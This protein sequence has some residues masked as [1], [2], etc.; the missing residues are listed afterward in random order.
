MESVTIFYS[1]YSSKKI[2]D[3]PVEEALMSIKKPSWRHKKRVLDIREMVK[4]GKDYEKKKAFLPVIMWTGTFFNSKVAGL[5]KPNNF[6]YVDIDN[7]PSIDL[8]TIPFV[9]AYWRSVSG[10]G[11]G[12]LV[13]SKNICHANYSATYR[14]VADMFHKYG[15]IVDKQTCNI[16][17]GNA[18]SYDPNLYINEDAV[19][20]EAKE[21]K[22]S[23][24]KNKPKLEGN[25]ITK[26]RGILSN[27]TKL[28]GSY[29][30][31]PG[32]GRHE[33]ILQYLMR[34]HLMGV[35][36]SDALFFLKSKSIIYHDTDRLADI[37][38]RDEQYNGA[39]YTDFSQLSGTI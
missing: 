8:S 2:A 38:Y 25:Y 4:Q 5:A 32:A 23:Q 7:N 31:V 27:L 30:N 18:A 28:L 37:V 29:R 13:K 33:F 35:N 17:R 16:N 19:V 15:V 36:R 12:L 11:Y 10:R 34:A 39:A 6:M 9:Y 26:C 14:K 20:V 24:P 3:R 22:V 21:V 1:R